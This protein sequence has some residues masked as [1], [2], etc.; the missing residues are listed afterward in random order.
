MN[1][2]FLRIECVAPDIAA[3]QLED[4][5]TEIADALFEVEGVID[6]DL[7]LDIAKRALTFTMILEATDEADA[8]TGAISAARTAL[9][10]A[11]KGTPGW[12]DHYRLARQDVE[13]Q[14]ETGHVPA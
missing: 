3:D 14:S 13:R 8:M 12:E 7:E 5:F 11:G 9:H 1:M 6:P 10:M 4:D 2:F